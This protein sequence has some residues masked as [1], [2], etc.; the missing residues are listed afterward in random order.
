MAPILLLN[1]VSAAGEIFHN[2]ATAAANQQAKT[3]PAPG[4]APSFPAMLDK[5][6]SAA[7]PT[8]A[9]LATARK[10][11]ASQLYRSADVASAM[12]ASSAPGPFQ[13]Q[14]EANGSASLRAADGTVK[15]VN[16]SPEMKQAAQQLYTLENPTAPVETLQTTRHTAGLSPAKS[17]LVSEN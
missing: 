10:D 17:V 6:A 4:T 7:A 9:D 16:L 5:T 11:L 3:T 14:L 1:A 8:A 12:N 13:L 15:P 2:L